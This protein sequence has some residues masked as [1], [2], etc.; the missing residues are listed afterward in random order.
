MKLSKNTEVDITTLCDFLDLTPG[1]ITQLLQEHENVIAKAAANRYRLRNSC[2]GYIAYL[3]SENRPGAASTELIQER[4]RALQLKNDLLEHKTMYVEE[5]LFVL[6][7]II[8]ALV[9]R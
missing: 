2:R 3:R 4:T 5:S 8:G 1:R 6:D 9:S 7:E